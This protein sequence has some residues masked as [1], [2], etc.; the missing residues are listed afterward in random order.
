MKRPDLSSYRNR[1]ALM[2]VGALLLVGLF[3]K[4]K[5]GSTV[6]RWQQH[7]A[8][9]ADAVPL[10]QLQ[11]ERN[12]LTTRL[13]ALDVQLASS[14]D[15]SAGWKPVLDL[16]TENKVAA[17]VSLAGV[18]EEHVMDQEGMQVRTLPISLQG[19][20]ADLVNALDAV[21]RNAHGVHLLTVDL[22]AKA[23]TYNA[24]RK[25][26]ATLYLQTLSR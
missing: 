10:T 25:L 5:L 4:K 6:A 1:V 13:A 9:L 16:L 7:Q 21:E 3:W 19:G 17:G 22:H 8:W 23:T 11:N 26:V 15:P 14:A 18:S 24:P 12:A 2:A 20:T